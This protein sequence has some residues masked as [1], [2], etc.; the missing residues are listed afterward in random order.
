[1]MA[2]SAKKDAISALLDRCEK[3]LEK[4]P[5][6]VD[7]LFTKGVVFAKIHRYEESLRCLEEVISIN[8]DY[9]GIHRLKATVVRLM[10]KETDTPTT[11][12]A[13]LGDI[14]DMES[15]RKGMEDGSLENGDRIPEIVER[16]LSLKTR[17]FTAENLHFA[18]VAVMGFDYERE[19]VE[20]SLEIL[21]TP[22]LRILEKDGERYTFTT[23]AKTI[24][25]RMELLERVA[26]K[27][28]AMA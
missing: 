5:R 11:E 10:S 19:E 24:L 17:T 28:R 15:E 8:P 6:D 20:K 22:P 9:P 16:I 25:S 1:M 27:S 26:R 4:N 18:L 7:T 2:G 3:E 12:P 23:D 21:S 13:L 14:E